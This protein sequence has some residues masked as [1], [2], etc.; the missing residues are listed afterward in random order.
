MGCII[1]YYSIHYS[2]CISFPL[3]A[4]RVIIFHIFF[5]DHVI[6]NRRGI[7][8]RLGILH[9]T[10]NILIPVSTPAFAILPIYFCHLFHRL[11][12]AIHLVFN[13]SIFS[14]NIGAISS[15]EF[16]VA[17]YIT[18]VTYAPLLV[19]LYTLM[20]PYEGSDSHTRIDQNHP[21]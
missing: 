19:L 16:G 8:I 18:L 2:T 5:F 4:P 13:L 10:V 11:T 20:Y 15:Y 7:D 3:L 21:L 6:Y 17:M 9:R 14:L 1:L 12:V